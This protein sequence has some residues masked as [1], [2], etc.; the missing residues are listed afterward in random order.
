MQTNRKPDSFV[1]QAESIP[2]F[3]T[4]SR[5]AWSLVVFFSRMG[6][7]ASMTDSPNRTLISARLFGPCVPQ[8]IRRTLPANSMPKSSRIFACGLPG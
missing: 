5:M 4:R 1:S 2:T 8:I 3:I 7:S 6:V